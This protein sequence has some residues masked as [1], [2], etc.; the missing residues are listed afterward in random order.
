[1]VNL[2]LSTI[3]YSTIFICRSCVLDKH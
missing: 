1:L 2:K 3:F